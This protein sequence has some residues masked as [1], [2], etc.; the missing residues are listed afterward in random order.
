VLLDALPDSDHRS[1]IVFIARGIG[2]HSVDSM[3]QAAQPI[4]CSRQLGPET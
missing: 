1:R 3:D 4:F 2:A